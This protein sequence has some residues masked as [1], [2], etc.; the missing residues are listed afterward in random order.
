MTSSIGGGGWGNHF[1]PEKEKEMILVESSGLE[2]K[3]ALFFFEREM[4]KHEKYR[5]HKHTLTCNCY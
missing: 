2:L 4:L 1:F 3:K 5:Q